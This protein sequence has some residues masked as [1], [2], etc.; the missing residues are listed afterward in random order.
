MGKTKGDGTCLCS[1]RVLT[2][3]ENTRPF[4][5]PNCR[6]SLKRQRVGLGGSMMQK[7]RGEQPSTMHGSSLPEPWTLERAGIGGGM[8]V[9]GWSPCVARRDGTLDRGCGANLPIQPWF[10]C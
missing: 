8:A 1:C 4:Q 7:K 9:A 3:P 6:E 10:I 5:L 2:G